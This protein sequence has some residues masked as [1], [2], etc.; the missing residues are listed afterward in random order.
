M[1]VKTGL[2]YHI[3]MEK[4]IHNPKDIVV[5]KLYKTVRK[6]YRDIVLY[7][8]G[9]NHSSYEKFLII[10]MDDSCNLIGRTVIHDCIK[11]V[12]LWVEGFE[13]QDT[14]L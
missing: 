8:G 3:D 6:E 2:E 7:L 13:E 1:I 4:I 14:T 9:I 5:G 10:V 11:P 12:G